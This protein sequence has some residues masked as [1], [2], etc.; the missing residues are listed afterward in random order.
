MPT[1]AIV[2]G[3]T[4]TI[5]MQD[6]LPPHIHARIAEHQAQISILTGDILKGSLPAAKRKSVQAWLAQNRGAVAFAW[7]EVRAGRPV[8]GL[9]T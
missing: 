3:V 5:F 4:I 1:I 2:D 6:H 9:L 8:K 7:T